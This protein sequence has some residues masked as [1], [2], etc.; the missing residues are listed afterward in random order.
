MFSTH[1]G[2]SLEG[3]LC[4]KAELERPLVVTQTPFLVWPRNRPG[5][6]FQLLQREPRFQAEASV[7]LLA[8]IF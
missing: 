8:R 1:L 6:C 3:Q 7:H 2:Q 5:A 4:A